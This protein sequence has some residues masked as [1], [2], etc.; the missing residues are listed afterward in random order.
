[1]KQ[2]HEPMELFVEVFEPLTLPNHSITSISQLCKIQR[3]LDDPVRRTVATLE[4]RFR[5]S[6]CAVENHRLILNP[7][8]YNVWKLARQERALAE[9]GE[10]ATETLTVECAPYLAEMLFPNVLPG[11][12]K[13]FGGLIGLRIFNLDAGAVRQNIAAH[14]TD[15]GI[16]IFGDDARSGVEALDARITASVAIPTGHRL[17][18]GVGAVA[19][20]DLRPDDRILISREALGLPGLGQWLQSIERANRIECDSPNLIRRCVEARLGLGLIFGFGGEGQRDGLT[21]RPIA[22]VEEQRLCFYLPRRAAD[23]SEPARA[24]MDEIRKHL[25]SLKAESRVS[26]EPAT[27]STPLAVGDGDFGGNPMTSL[28]ESN[29]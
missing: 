16:G 12:M 15:F 28:E 14:I 2:F 1:M 5:G 3:I 8:G 11:L 13:G 7:L 22:G 29:S 4:K 27:V 26:A 10:E 17:Q 20:A 21:V 9:S 24:L 19:S 23:L 18:D 25:E 6:L